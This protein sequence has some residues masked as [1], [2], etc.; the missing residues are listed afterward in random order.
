[1]SNPIE[2]LA[3]AATTTGS[4]LDTALRRVPA[5]R[6]LLDTLDAFGRDHMSLFA[7]SLSYYALLALF[8]LLLMLIALAS[9]LLTGENV[10][11]TVVRVAGEALPGTATEIESILRGIVE[12]RGPATIIGLLALM[13]S[14]SGV[15]DVVQTALNRAWRVPQPRAFLQQRLL[16]VLVIAV[17]GGLFIVGLFV[18]ALAGQVLRPALEMTSDLVPILS[19]VTGFSASFVAFTLLYK[20]FPHARIRWREAVAGALLAALLWELARNVYGLYLIRFAR[21]NLVYGSVGAVIGLLL[22]GYL[23]AVILLFGAEL[24]AVVGRPA[25]A[26]GLTAAL[27]GGTSPEADSPR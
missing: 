9:P 23:S 17:L 22:W 25:G 12:A 10:V 15:F 19:V 13:W 11:R 20:F 1:M 3:A 6:V 2:R 18:S 16:S 7:A 26:I 8:P 27:P 14:A 24:S 21:F 5:L 4:R